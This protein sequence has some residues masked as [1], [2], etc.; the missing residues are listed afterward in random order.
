MKKVLKFLG[1]LVLMCVFLAA[2]YMLSDSSLVNLPLPKIGGEA[3]AFGQAT[4]S[5]AP[6]TAA[7]A[8]APAGPVAEQAPGA[9]GSDMTLY[10]AGGAAALVLLVILLYAFKIRPA[11]K[12]R[13]MYEAFALLQR[14]NPSCFGKALELMS[15]AKFAGIKKEEIRE[16]DFATAYI[17]A[18]LQAYE[19][20][21]A[22]I[23]DLET[24]YAD[25]LLP[26]EA[27]LC[28]Y[29][30]NRLG[31]NRDVE[32]IWERYRD[33]VEDFP[34]TRMIVGA[35]FLGIASECWKNKKVSEAILYF[36]RLRELR[37]LGEYIPEHIDD[38]ETVN[39]I[40]AVYDKRYK[41]AREH[42]ELAVEEAE[43][44]KRP[45][46]HGEA[47]LFVC[48]WYGHESESMQKRIESLV[49]QADRMQIRMAKTKTVQCEFCKRAFKASEFA[50]NDKVY[51]PA[52]GKRFTAKLAAG[53]TAKD[54]AAV[55]SGAETF[56]RS[57][58]LL[59][60]LLRVMALRRLP[61][62]K[63]LP[64]AQGKKIGESLQKALPIDEG[65]SDIYLVRGLLVYY[66]TPDSGARAKAV[67]DLHKAVDLGVNVPEVLILLDK[68]D[69][70]LEFHKNSPGYFKK[71]LKKYITDKSI[72]EAARLKLF[73]ALDGYSGQAGI[74]ERD[75]EAADEALEPSVSDLRYR[76][77]HTDST[78]QK[79]VL[80][81]LKDHRMDD[82]V[83]IVEKSRENLASAQKGLTE[84]SDMAQDA[85][86]DLL[87]LSAPFMLG[88]SKTVKE[89]KAAKKPKA[90]AAK[91]VPL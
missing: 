38:Q 41:E 85:E 60:A 64:P 80:P 24:K 87:A 4:S 8:E 27:Y 23:H 62:G 42:F 70:I 86:V 51:C 16:I 54:G 76:Y 74:A 88:E 37:V 45:S 31:E 75:I 79:I 11:R 83:G 22:A 21:K 59:D 40:V 84:A 20:A 9:A 91:E 53:A 89:K 61:A 82:A 48:D 12:R 29:I 19:D 57:V 71:Y 65:F 73:K 18:R 69:K 58:Y 77:R 67:E 81:Y 28:A 56:W 52:C 7:P 68:E 34:E 30:H 55:L 3:A 72:D 26:E 78:A 5:V 15:E 50:M 1:F 32:R 43:R 10:I 2:G 25:S 66:N 35:A 46:P 14:D 6:N 13:P 33:A 63:G 17:H 90:A 36:E 44:K 47:G 49:S 39:G